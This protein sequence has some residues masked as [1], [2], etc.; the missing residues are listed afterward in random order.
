MKWRYD[1]SRR[2]YVGGQWE[3]STA[4]DGSFYPV[5]QKNP[6]PY[7]TELGDAKAW[8]EAKEQAKPAEPL[9]KVGSVWGVPGKPETR[10]FVHWT[11]YDRV[12]YTPLKETS[13]FSCLTTLWQSWVRETGAVDLVADRAAL[14]KRADAAEKYRPDFANMAGMPDCEKWGD[15][16]TVLV[17]RIEKIIKRAET[18]EHQQRLWEQDSRDKAAEVERWKKRAE[19]AEKE[20]DELKQKRGGTVENY[21]RQIERLEAKAEKFETAN[22]RL[23]EKLAAAEKERDDL[24]AEVARI[25]A[26]A[27]LIAAAPDLLAALK[28]WVDY[29][30]SLDFDP[31]DP[32][33]EARKLYHGKR[34][35][36]SR[37]AIAKAEG[38][39]NG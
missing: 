27:N 11:K 21:I 29:M 28:S 9:P 32:L 7:F 23:A 35:E 18:A 19:A 22:D 20:R 38:G 34:M 5:G 16:A 25:K 31:S 24:R 12:A 1:E 26:D 37:A 10:R 13:M 33:S 36:A 14:V 8:C 3:L 4:N 15:I 2:R 30:D 6:P 17:A 39:G